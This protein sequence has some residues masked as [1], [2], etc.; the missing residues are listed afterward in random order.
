MRIDRRIFSFCILTPQDHLNETMDAQM[1]M[2]DARRPN[3]WNASQHHHDETG[4]LKMYDSG[5]FDIKVDTGNDT[6]A[7]A[8]GHPACEYTGTICWRLACVAPRDSIWKCT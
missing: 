7:N 3:P 6:C 5:I 1:L 4:C 8:T 2:V